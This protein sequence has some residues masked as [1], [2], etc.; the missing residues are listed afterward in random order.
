MNSR[1]TETYFHRPLDDSVRAPQTRIPAS[2]EDADG[3][4]ALRIQHVLR[5]SLMSKRTSSAPR[6]TSFAGALNTPRSA[7]VRA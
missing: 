1:R 7:S 4:H 5:A 3:V 6:T 2:R